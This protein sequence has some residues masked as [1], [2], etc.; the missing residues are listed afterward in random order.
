MS[1]S[2]LNTLT[3]RYE[4]NTPDHQKRP[5][6]LHPVYLL[7]QKYMRGKKDEYILHATYRKDKT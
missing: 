2:N 7:T 3:Q 5:D 6:D 1:P 4:N